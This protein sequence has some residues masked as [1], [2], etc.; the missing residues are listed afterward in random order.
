MVME[1]K[2][3]NVIQKIKSWYYIFWPQSH[4]KE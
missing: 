2:T 3:E 1:S 4:N